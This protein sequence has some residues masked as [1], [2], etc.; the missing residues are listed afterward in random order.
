MLFNNWLELVFHYQHSL[1]VMQTVKSVSWSPNTGLKGNRFTNYEELKILEFE[2]RHVLKPFGLFQV[3]FK[4]L[5][6]FA[7]Y[8]PHFYTPLIIIYKHF[9]LFSYVY[10]HTANFYLIFTALNTSS[11][12]LKCNTYIKLFPFIYDSL[13]HFK[14]NNILFVNKTLKRIKVNENLKSLWQHWVTFSW[15]DSSFSDLKSN[16]K[17]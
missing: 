8:L 1:F 3:V 4:F 16:E 11:Q 14:N 6:V 7:P 10:L 15:V 5:Q 9:Q 12:M 2:G 17:I 13:I